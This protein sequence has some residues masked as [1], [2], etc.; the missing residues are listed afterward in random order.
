MIES[1]AR[2]VD[3]DYKVIAY[4]AGG[5]AILPF[6]LMKEGFIKAGI[7]VDSSICHGKIIHAYGYN[8]DFTDVPKEG[9][10]R[11]SND[12]KC[13]ESKGMF[14]ESQICSFRHSIVT[15]LLNYW[16]HRK[17]PELFKKL[18]DGTHIRKNDKKTP[19]KPMS[20]WN[21]FHQIQGFGLGGLPSFLLN[22]E[23]RKAKQSHVVIISHPKD[24][25]P[26]T[27][28]NIIGLKKFKFCTYKDIL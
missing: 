19:F 26:I 12:I 4:R 1:I 14:V 3:P 15:T 16:Y 8:L 28:K 24:I 10:Y 5:W 20:K 6:S 25:M 23:I 17:Y 2:E 13:R 18:A 22:Y 21:F 7:K 27:C 11:F 9:I